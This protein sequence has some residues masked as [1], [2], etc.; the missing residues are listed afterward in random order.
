[1]SRATFSGSRRWLL[2]A[3]V[4]FVGACAD[5]ADPPSEV[6]RA[7]VTITATLTP[8]QQATIAG[9]SVEVTGSGIGTPI[10]VTLAVSGATVNGTVQVPVGVSRTFTVRAFD[11]EGR[12]THN[13]SATTTVAAGTN[14]ALTVRLAALAGGVPIDVTIGSYGVSITPATAS[15]AVDGE[16]TLIATFTGDAANAPASAISWGALNPALVAV[17]VAPDGRSA[18]VRGRVAGTTRV[19]VS[20]EGAAGAS[21]VTVTAMG[22]GGTEPPVAVINGP[23]AGTTTSAIQFS[24]T[25]SR[26]P[27]GRPLT[28]VWSNLGFTTSEANPLARFPTAGSMSV[29]L[30][31]TDAAGM[32]DTATTT[33]T[34]TGTSQPRFIKLLAG[35]DHV[36]AFDETR[37]VWCWGRNDHGQLGDGSNTNR[38]VPTVAVMPSAPDELY[39]GGDHNCTMAFSLKIFYCWG[40]NDQGQL[41]LGT[42][43]DRNQPT[44]MTFFSGST[45]PSPSPV[46][47]GGHHAC[48]SQGGTTY[49]WGANG[50]GQLG[51]GSTTSRSIPVAALAPTVLGDRHGCRVDNAAHVVECW[52]ANDRQ[53]FGAPGASSTTPVRVGFPG[54]TAPSL[55]SLAA[56]DGHTCGVDASVNEVWCWGANDVGQ[57]GNGTANGDAAPTRITSPRMRNA[58]AGGSHTCGSAV[59]GGDLL[60][61]RGIVWCW[62]ANGSGQLGDATTT[63]RSSPVTVASSWALWESAAGG[64]FTCALDGRGF[65]WC[66]GDNTYGQ[67][68]DGTNVSRSVPRMVLMP[69]R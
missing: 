58:R 55:S 59:D 3:G 28:Y 25:G 63:D 65:A 40:R 30:V 19:V 22:G 14:P 16:V 15:V 9:M 61:F 21:E 8:A 50:F 39:V 43:A 47:F 66:W 51:D 48:V 4:L 44:V 26:D 12:E 5:P 32:K 23:Y 37:K 6:V 38:N 11:T 34:V 24:S 42:T 41:G 33:I 49:C 36:C 13:G 67:L 69:T 53:Q 56:A 27:D 20:Y 45:K 62:G 29:S 1:M 46:G 64:A 52:G 35:N 68:G 18:V 31:V 57:H 10:I 17:T 54:G 2:A 7:P 60:E